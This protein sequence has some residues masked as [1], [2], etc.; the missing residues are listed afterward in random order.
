M[1]PYLQKM[2]WSLHAVNQCKAFGVQRCVVLFD[3]WWGW[4]DEGFRA[5]L[6]RSYPWLSFLYVPAACTPIGQPMDMGII[7]KFKAFVR[8]C[9]GR[10]ACNLV[11][12][13]LFGEGVVQPNQVDIPHDLPT[14]RRN[15][16]EWLS[17][18]V[19]HM[20][21]SDSAGMVH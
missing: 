15:I 1:V 7:A 14:L 8:K 21:Q 3:V 4:L 17:Q 2:I 11:T 19:K 10:W 12:S 6:R 5:W 13:Q 9:Y 16:T 20:N 18:S